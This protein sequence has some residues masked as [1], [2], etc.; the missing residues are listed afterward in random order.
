MGY[1]DLSS[2]EGVERLVRTLKTLYNVLVI[3]KRTGSLILRVACPSLEI[4]ENLWSDYRSGQL[5]KEAERCLVTEDF[6]KEFKLKE[7]KLRVEMSEE[8]YKACRHELMKEGEKFRA[9]DKIEHLFISFKLQYDSV[10]Y[11]VIHLHQLHSTGGRWV[12]WWYKQTNQ[13]KIIN[14]K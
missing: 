9:E 10:A 7:I 13:F 1:A 14:P 2:D 11:D 3:S 8:E 12:G 5:K 4:L 6:L